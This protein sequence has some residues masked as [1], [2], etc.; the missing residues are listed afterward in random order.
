MR[1]LRVQ[2]EQPAR[3]RELEHVFQQ[4]PQ[5]CQSILLTGHSDD[6]ARFQLLVG[7]AVEI[8]QQLFFQCLGIGRIFFMQQQRGD[9]GRQ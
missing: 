3:R 7:F 8:R 9:Q 6:D 1:H 4:R 5:H 2:V